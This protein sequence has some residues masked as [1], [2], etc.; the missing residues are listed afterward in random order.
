MKLICVCL[1]F[2][3]LVTGCYTNTPLTKDSPP[4]AAEVTFRLNDGRV[5]VSR[6]YERIAN[7]YHVIGT[8][9]NREFRTE[10]DFDGI[11]QD[12]QIKEVVIIELDITKTVI[13]A[14]LGV[15]IIV[16]FIALSK[17]VEIRLP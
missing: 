4:V 8:I 1:S 12:E 10:W 11:V 15:G 17:P 13:T 7:G 6:T 9:R 14:V 2:A 3:I 5:I 16:A